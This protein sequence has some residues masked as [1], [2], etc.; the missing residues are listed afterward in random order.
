MQNQIETTNQKANC[1]AMLMSNLM[2]LLTLLILSDLQF[3]STTKWS[4]D[5]CSGLISFDIRDAHGVV[6]PGCLAVGTTYWMAWQKIYPVNVAI[7][8]GR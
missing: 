1:V 8:S 3:R 2:L 5:H 4:S 7:V 6:V